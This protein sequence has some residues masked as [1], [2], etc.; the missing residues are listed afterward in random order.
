MSAF[1]FGHR[2]LEHWPLDPSITY[3]NH[4][5]V[6]VTPRRVLEAQRRIRDEIERQPSHFML[7]ELSDW[8]GRQ[9]S[10]PTRLRRAAAQVAAFVGARGDDLAFVDNAT[11]GANSVLRSLPFDSED[12]ILITGQTYG[13]VARA[14]EYAASVRGA[15]RRVVEVP[16]PR[17][18]PD[19]LVKR[20]EAGIGERTRLLLIDHVVSETALIIPV[21]EIARRCHARGV[22]V[23]VDG[24]HAPGMLDLDI[25]SLGV[26]WYAA[27]LH[28]WAH[29]P[30]SCGILW[31]APERQAGLHPP[32]ISW[33]LN[34][35]FLA[36]FDWVGTRDPSPWLA[37][38]EGL[39]FLREMDFAAVRS[40]NHALAWE[41]SQI[42]SRRWRVPFEIPESCIGS[43]VTVPLPE[44]LG[45]DEQQAGA[46]RD[47]LLFED[48][49][50]VHVHP[51]HGRLWARVSAQVYNDRSDIEQLAE[52]VA[53]R[54]DLR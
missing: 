10:E 35:G 47:Q 25:G 4:G 49:I 37:A 44:V 24:A 7:R 18:D 38:P 52:A 19:E 46:L 14:V 23:L 22:P 17:F 28:K 48:R 42:L 15:R 43:M 9:R 20:I 40:Y 2:M 13:G 32:V 53:H 50:E 54:A 26:D 45:N 30:R 27:N 34:T 8:V 36:E 39:A 1:T 16:Y 29:A 51:G 11:A 33:G 3:L 21:R 12:E 5:T 6:G 31:A 41:A